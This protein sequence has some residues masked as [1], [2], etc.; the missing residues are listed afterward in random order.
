MVICWTVKPSQTL[1]RPGSHQVLW[2]LI[3]DAGRNGGNGGNGW[4][5]SKVDDAKWSNLLNN[6][7][8]STLLQLLLLYLESQSVFPE[9]SFMLKDKLQANFRDCWGVCNI[10]NGASQVGVWGG[11][12]IFT[13]IQGIC[14]QEADEMLGST[15]PFFL[16][17]A[18]MVG[19]APG[20]TGLFLLER[21]AP[22]R[23]W[24]GLMLG[25]SGLAN[26]SLG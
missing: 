3:L 9:E 10:M 26:L 2:H 13:E 25:C 20:F 21:K 14:I 22:N 1:S 8:G 19:W 15:D 17:V 11:V 18:A 23:C 5:G 24:Q 16:Q 6:C 7:F 4:M 12:L